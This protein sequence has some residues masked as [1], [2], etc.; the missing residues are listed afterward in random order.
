[1]GGRVLKSFPFNSLK[2]KINDDAKNKRNKE[3]IRK[4]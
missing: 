2:T 4:D 3:K 1:M